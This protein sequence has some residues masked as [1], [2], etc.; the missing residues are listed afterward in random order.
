MNYKRELSE[1][2]QEL[3]LQADITVEDREYSAEEVGKNINEIGNFIISKSSKNGDIYKAQLEYMP[4]V[5]I[6][7]NCVE[8]KSR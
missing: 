8:K 3:L 5:N 7:K 6:L 4:F 1:K 2:N